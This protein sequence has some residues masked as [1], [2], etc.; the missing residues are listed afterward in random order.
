VLQLSAVRSGSDGDRPGYGPHSLFEG[1]SMPEDMAVLIAQAVEKAI[2]PF[3]D[4]ISSLEET[5][6]F[7]REK[8]AALEATQATLSDNQFI[9]LKLTNDL[10]E[11]TKKEAQ[12][13]Q[14]DRGDILRALL[15]AN[16]GKMLAKDARQKMHLSRSRFSELL[17]AMQGDIEV[18]PY[19]LNKRQNVLVLK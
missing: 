12:P 3:Q 14:K 2:Q 6:A 17:A 4:R 5:I 9:Q 13:L 18:K 1:S 7:L 19:Y 15:A 11:A 16:S 8:A 10:R